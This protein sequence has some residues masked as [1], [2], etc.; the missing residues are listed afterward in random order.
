MFLF[1]SFPLGTRSSVNPKGEFHTD[2][3]T[4]F[5]VDP[6]NSD[7][8]AISVDTPS[9]AQV[10][11]QPEETPVA[12]E[13]VQPMGEDA[14]Y[15]IFWKLQDVFSNPPH[16]FKATNFEAFKTGLDATLAKFKEVPIVNQRIAPDA[17][18]GTKRKA[19]E[20]EQPGANTFNPKYLTSRDLFSLEVS[21]ANFRSCTNYLL[22]QLSDLAFQRHILVQALIVLDFVLSLTEKAKKRLA[23]LTSQKALQYGFTL[24]DV[25][26]SFHSLLSIQPIY[27]LLSITPNAGQ[28]EW[29]EKTK[30]TIARYINEGP[31]GK[32]Y[33]RMVDTVL[34]RDKNWV[35]W[36]LEN[37][38]LITR[39]P[40]ASEP[41]TQCKRGA[42]N[43]CAT[44]RL[45][46]APINS[47]DLMFL[48]DAENLNSLERSDDTVR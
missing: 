48:S 2:N 32:F 39:Q 19:D 5:E 15:P 9:A 25:D 27:S 34:S 10:S 14:L 12:T 41:F 21:S 16:L 1:Q 29:A 44:K 43:Y 11:S 20:M 3:V 22:V 42:K 24:N 7:T 18:K 13:S 6:T 45:R 31:D 46:N 4:T 40:L 23:H 36:K 17:K 26:V 47:L 33:F 8:A 38:P 37:C 35:R 28:T 30:K